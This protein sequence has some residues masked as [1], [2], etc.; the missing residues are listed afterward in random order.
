MES[1]SFLKNEN[2]DA[3]VEATILFPVMIM[4]FAALV[5]LSAILPTRAA[6]QRATQYAAIVLATERSDTWLFYDLNSMN[7]YW[8]K[9][10]KRLG[11]IYT[12]ILPNAGDIS[13]RAEK[14]VKDSGKKFDP[15]LVK[16]FVSVKDKFKDVHNFRKISLQT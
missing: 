15:Q 5:I 8:E 2:G 13:V 1:K 7:F 6:L 10:K 12:P 14:I 16:V 11:T 3:V 4:I 9:D